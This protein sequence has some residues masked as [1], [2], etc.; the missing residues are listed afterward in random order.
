[1]YGYPSPLSLS[2]NVGVADHKELSPV[3]VWR[4]SSVEQ[5]CVELSQNLRHALC[6]GVRVATSDGPLRI[7]VLTTEY[8]APDSIIKIPGNYSL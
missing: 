2:S 6:V 5:R 1:M 8:C 4:K 3:E 7:T